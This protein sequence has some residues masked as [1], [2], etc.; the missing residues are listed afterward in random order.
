LLAAPRTNP[1][2]DTGINA[3]IRESAT[4]SLKD[5]QTLLARLESAH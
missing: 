3:G 5:A 4:S 2:D 1:E